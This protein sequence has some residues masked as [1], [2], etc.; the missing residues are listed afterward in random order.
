MLKDC[1]NIIVL[2]M[3]IITFCFKDTKK[4][5][6]QNLISLILSMLLLFVKELAVI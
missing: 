2:F 1:N 6:D 3:E 5:L 4:I